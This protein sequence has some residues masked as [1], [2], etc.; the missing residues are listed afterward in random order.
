MSSR[1]EE[2]EGFLEQKG[3]EKQGIERVPSAARYHIRIFDNEPSKIFTI[4]L[5]FKIN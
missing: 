3:I 5:M 4:C 1:V 2:T